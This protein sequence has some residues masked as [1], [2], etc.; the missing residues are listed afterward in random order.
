MKLALGHSTPLWIAAL[1][2]TLG[3][4]AMFA[5]LAARGGVRLPPRNDLP[6]VVSVGLLHMLA[7]A[8]LVIFALRFVPPGR[9]SVLSYTTPLWVV[10]LA[11]LLGERPTARAL[12]GT[13]LGLAGMALLFSPTS[14]DW[15]DR[16]MVFGQILLMLAA[17]AWS[18]CIVHIRG[19]RWQASPLEL[20]PWQMLLAAAPLVI[21]ALLVDGPAPGDFS[22]GFWMTTLYTGV[23]ATAFA[24]W[25][26]VEANR[27]LSAITASNALLA[28]P[29]VGL[30]VSACVTGEKMDFWLIVG[31]LMMLAGIAIVASARRRQRSGAAIAGQTGV[32]RP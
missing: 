18:I 2:F 27:R 1:R 4:A 13:F 24:Y 16:Q 31:M 21:A 20:A 22:P 8:T 17:I 32:L 26:V 3:A 9:S 19:H 11:M 28:V 12:G 23:L 6:I 30:T 14:L 25:A 15:S 29:I 10:P 7:N 5:V